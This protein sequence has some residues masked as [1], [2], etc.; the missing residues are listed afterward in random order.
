MFDACIDQ[1][2]YSPQVSFQ[3]GMVVRTVD[4]CIAICD[5]T[6]DGGRVVYVAA[7][8]LNGKAGHPACPGIRPYECGDAYSFFDHQPF[9]E[10]SANTP[11]RAG[12]HEFLS[13]EAFAGLRY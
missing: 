3:I 9:H 12:D 11:G 4:D 13:P 10:P 8:H 7:Y 5:G 1:I 2:P 6:V